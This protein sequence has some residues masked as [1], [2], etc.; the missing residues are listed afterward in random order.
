MRRE[1]Y[2]MQVSQPKVIT[3]E[4]DGKTVE[5][6]EE[7]TIDTPSEFQGSIIERLGM[8]GFM[9][10]NMVTKEN[11]TRMTLEG[12]TRGL[13]GY[14]GQFV[15]DTKGEGIL[16]SRVI[17][18]K[19]FSG[20]IQKRV[21]GS[22]ISMATGTAVGF[23]LWNLQDRGL[24]YI[25]PSTE[26]YEGMVVGNTSKGEEMVVNPL[27][28]KQLTNVRASGSDEAIVLVPAWEITIERGLETMSDDEYLEITPHFTRLRKQFLTENDRAKARR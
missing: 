16:S 7:V 4:E 28:G 10:T 21:V 3:K 14:R 25:T 13:L 23:A 19:H 1:G 24:L 22:M 27:K 26:V 18:F 5:P 2:E 8:R 20:S 6:F 15:I 12:P 11:T 17:G 9:L